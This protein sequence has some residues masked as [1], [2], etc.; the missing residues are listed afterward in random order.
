MVTLAAVVAIAIGGGAAA[1]AQQAPT[2]PPDAVGAV[3]DIVGEVESLD[4]TESETRKGE[5]LTLALTSDVLFALDKA[6]LTAKARDRLQ[7]AAE[8]IKA[9]GAGGPVKIEGHTDDQGSDSYNDGLSKRRAEAV[10]AALAGMLTGQNVTLQARGFGEQRPKL[11]NIVGGKPNERN[12]AK[13]RR[14][15]IIFIVKQ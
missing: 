14:V 6:E 7:D 12:R 1:L 11:P 10:R 2:L 4:R 9:E 3:V 13:N 5:T 8:R 15:E